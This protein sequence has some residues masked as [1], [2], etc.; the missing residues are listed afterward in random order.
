MFRI[1][2]VLFFLVSIIGTSAKAE[3]TIR[4]TEGTYEPMKT[5]VPVFQVT[6]E[7]AEEYAEQ[8]AEVVRS[9]LKSS[10]LFNIQDPESFIQKNVEITDTPGFTVWKLIQSD[11]LVIG[12]VEMLED[13]LLR[14]EFRLWDIYG[15]GEAASGRYTTK[16]ENW[17]R[18]AHKI[19]DNI[20]TRLTGELGFFDT[21]IVYIAE[22]GPKTNRVKR[23]AMM[24]YDG[25]NLRYLTDGSQT[26]LTP[27]FSPSLQQITY[28]SYEQGLPTVFLYNIESDRR[29]VLGDFDGM[30]FAPRFSRDGES[31]LLTQATDGN[32]D[33]FMMDL[34]TYRSRR[35]T[36]HSAIDTSPSMSPDSKQI[37]F[38]SDRG[39]SPQL[40][41]MNVDGKNMVCP[42][43]ERKKVCRITFG[44]GSY[45]TPVW[46]PRGD[47]IA[48]TKQANRKFYIGVI[49]IDGE[50]ER[51]LSESYL[52]EGPDWSP[53]GRVVIF[54]REE[55]PG[56][57]ARLWS[58]DLTGR[59]L[60]MIDTPTDASDPAWSPL[61]E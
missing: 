30:T 44:R 34:R 12:H 37:V 16:Q 11:A 17:R 1:I 3:L 24:D 29:E 10:G 19:S 61:L 5:A 58:V 56:A 18:T 54:F 13:G 36:N 43:G 50:G 20:Y 60:R 38:T 22:T 26:V 4:L 15:E 27:R 53:N 6:G 46:S 42:S 49:G 40:Y 25:A 14:V 9:D 28:M 23:L 35:L 52:D 47:L 21:R 45:S 41:I 59:N 32:S 7:G 48:F 55:R 31:V 57:S 33:I 51:L 8:I 2:F 39:G